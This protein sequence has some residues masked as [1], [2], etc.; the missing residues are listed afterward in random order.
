MKLATRTRYGTRLM[1]ELALNYDKDAVLLKDI[2]KAQRISEK[3]LSQIIILIKNAGLVQA[4]RGSKGGY[5]LTRKPE[6]ITLKDIL[7]ILEDNFI[8][9]DCLDLPSRCKAKDICI[10][11]NV[12]NDLSKTIADS[13]EKITLADLV[14][15]YKEKKGIVK[16]SYEI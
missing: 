2:A 4:F 9:V 6:L 14:K 11:R 7:G 8:L 16:Y 12:W 13:L 1:L 15:Q 5:K 10:M 3:Y